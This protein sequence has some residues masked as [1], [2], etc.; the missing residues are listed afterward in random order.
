MKKFML[1][2]ALGCFVALSFSACKPKTESPDA[3]VK[4]FL[5][6][7]SED[8]FEKAMEL[9]A[10]ETVE[11]L[12]QW[13]QEGFNL[14]KG[15]VIEVTGCEMLSETQAECTFTADGEQAIIH[16]NLIDGKW[17]VFMEK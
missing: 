12:K 8:N 15:N 14:Y 17:K 16:A 5:T 10:P 2:F 4:A 3:V 6:Y 1:M 7:L 13:Q 11:I 9:S